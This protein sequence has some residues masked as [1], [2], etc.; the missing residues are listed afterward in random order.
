MIPNI[1]NDPPRPK[2]WTGVMG[3][4]YVFKIAAI[5]AACE[6]HEPRLKDEKKQKNPKDRFR[7]KNFFRGLTK[8]GK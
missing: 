6:D 1:P 3:V 7:D 5:A 8:K 4:G 2:I